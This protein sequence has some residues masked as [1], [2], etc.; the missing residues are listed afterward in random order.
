MDDSIALMKSYFLDFLLLCS[1]PDNQNRVT[2][3]LELSQ[4]SSAKSI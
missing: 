2:S 4:L 3:Q 1:N